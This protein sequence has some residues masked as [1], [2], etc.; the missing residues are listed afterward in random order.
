MAKEISI[1]KGMAGRAGQS[2]AQAG[3]VWTVKSPSPRRSDLVRVKSAPGKVI[4]E[5]KAA[6]EISG[7]RSGLFGAVRQV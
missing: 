5:K 1:G 6:K 7:G 3:R 4:T 2:F